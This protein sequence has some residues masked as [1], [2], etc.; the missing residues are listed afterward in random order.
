MKAVFILLAVGFTALLFAGA[1]HSDPRMEINDN[2]FHMILDADNTDNEIFVG[3][4]GAQIAA[5][6]NGGANGYAKRVEIMTADGFELLL[7]NHPNG[8]VIT[9]DDSATQCTMVE[10]NGTAY[11]S[12]DWR[13]E[14]RVRRVGSRAYIVHYFLSCRDGVEQ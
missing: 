3:D 8:L 6:G 4:G 5:D 13:S 12:D 14:I 2:F 1:A 11:A 10:S 9:S 7:G